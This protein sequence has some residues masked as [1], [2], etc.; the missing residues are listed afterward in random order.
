MIRPLVETDLA[1]CLTLSLSAGWNQS[2]AD[3]RVMLALGEG[4]GIVARGAD[5]ARR[6]AASVVAVPY[7][8]AAPD[9]G[10]CAWVSMVLVLPEFQRRGYASQLLRHALAWLAP[11]RMTPVLDATPAGYPVYLREGFHPTWG[12]RRYRREPVTRGTAESGRTRR[13][14][15][16]DWP[17]VMA[18]DRPAFGG[19]R[20]ALLRDLARRMPAAARL[21]LRDGRVAGYCFGR[22]G[23]EACQLGPMLSPDRETSL[24]LLDDALAGVAT[25]VYIDL[26][27]R[28]LALLQALVER[29]FVLQRPFTRMVHGATVA[30]GDPAQLVLMAGPELG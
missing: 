9:S 13:L 7:E 30:P 2:E 24:A 11:R 23:R 25:P 5:G 10:G 17:A 28:H 22:G 16:A 15:D 20:E 1:G 18:L 29:G 3:W 8:P 19:D 26:A 6:L 14:E 4:W 21:T 27:D 12:F